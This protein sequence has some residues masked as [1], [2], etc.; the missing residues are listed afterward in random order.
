MKK[1]SLFFIQRS[2]NIK[3][4]NDIHLLQDEKENT[5]IIDFGSPSNLKNERNLDCQ[6]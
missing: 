4:G 3:D 5:I 6:Y 1:K 2:Q